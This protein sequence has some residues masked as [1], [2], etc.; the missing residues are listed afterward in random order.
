MG[1]RSGVFT[2]QVG[3]NSSFKQGAGL[4]PRA[5]TLRLTMNCLASWVLSE[6]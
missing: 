3:I 5:R 1:S 2:S 4:L 6:H